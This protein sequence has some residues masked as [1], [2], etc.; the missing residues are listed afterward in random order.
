MYLY[1]E[2]R[3]IILGG[4]SKSGGPRYG[5]TNNI[6]VVLVKQKTTVTLL[7]MCDLGF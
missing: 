5:V 1:L 4:R 6:I 7:H 3:K 2:A